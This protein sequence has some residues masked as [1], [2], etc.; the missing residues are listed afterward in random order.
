MLITTAPAAS[1][2]MAVANAISNFRRQSIWRH[3]AKPRGLKL[4]I[5]TPSSASHAN[6]GYVNRRILILSAL[7]NSELGGFSISLD[8]FLPASVMW[9]SQP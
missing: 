9:K 2:T 3:S 5:F 4:P 8:A 6:D 1:I 7:V